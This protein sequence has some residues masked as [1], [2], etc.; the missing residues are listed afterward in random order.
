MEQQVFKEDR[1]Y[2]ARRDHKVDK[3]QPELLE[4]PVPLEQ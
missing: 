1:V 3:V 4:Q 2:K